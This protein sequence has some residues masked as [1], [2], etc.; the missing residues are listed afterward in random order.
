MD[1]RQG[2]GDITHQQRQRHRHTA[3]LTVINTY[4]Q[5]TE[6][7]SNDPVEFQ[8]SAQRAGINRAGSLHGRLSFLPEYDIGH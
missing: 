4:S 3:Q 2:A 5:L 1:R 6:T 8:R 7:S